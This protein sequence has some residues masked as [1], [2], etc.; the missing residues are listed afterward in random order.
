MAVWFLF[1]P[2]TLHPAEIGAP[3]RRAGRP[4]PRPADLA[5]PPRAGKTP[6]SA[7]AATSG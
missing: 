6:P 2:H 3:A 5:E 7:A 1:P 4:S